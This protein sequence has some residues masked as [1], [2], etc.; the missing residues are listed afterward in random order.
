MYILK[1]FGNSNL[2]VRTE[3]FSSEFR[4]IYLRRDLTVVVICDKFT[5][6]DPHINLSD[7]LGECLSCQVFTQ[8]VKKQLKC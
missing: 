3:C 8:T 6:V 4:F 2:G 7:A 5:W 1:K